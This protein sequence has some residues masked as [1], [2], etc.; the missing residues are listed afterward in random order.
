[1]FQLPILNINSNNGKKHQTKLKASDLLLLPTPFFFRTVFEKE[2]GD[3][4][5]V[6]IKVEDVSAV[7][8]VVVCEC[9]LC[10]PKESILLS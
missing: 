2:V 8:S 3:A 5:W 9:S 6:A 7:A 4:S 1:M 10:V